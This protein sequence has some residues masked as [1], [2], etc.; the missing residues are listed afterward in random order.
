M[1]T[2]H[3]K[4][5]EF[6][7]TEG[8]PQCIAE[9]RVAGIK[10]E[11]DEMED[12][13]NSEGFTLARVDEIAPLIE[14]QEVLVTTKPGADPQ[15]VAFYNEALRLWEIAEARVIITNDDL[16]P[17]NDDLVIIRGIK[18]GME[19]KRKE[20]LKPF[21]DH[22]KET[23]EAYKALMEPIEQADKITSGKMLAFDAE[24]KR[25]RHE[26]EEINRKRLEAAEA[27]MRLKG[28]LSESVNLVEVMPEVPKRTQTDMGT[29]STMKVRKYRV[30]NFTELPDQY[31][32]ENSALLNKV[33]K[34]GIPSIPGVEIYTEDS[35][36]VTVR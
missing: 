35:L 4:H 20:Y 23:N 33:V 18:R 30:L 22:V 12:G 31:K 36:R 7:L 1:D 19:E 16:K 13:L 25:R 27:E 32:I 10:P 5:G 14:V 9:K 21:Q 34:A 3:C 15:F 26:Q 28:E 29:T 17:A 6:I 24:Q 8:C 2:G 11:Q